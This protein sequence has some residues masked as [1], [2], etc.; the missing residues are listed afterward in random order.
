M[1]SLANALSVKADDLLKGSPQLARWR[2]VVR[3]TPQ[4]SDAE[5]VTLSMMPAMLGYTSEAPVATAYPDPAAAPVPVPAEAARL[6]QE[7]R[8]TAELIR[9]VMRQLATDTALWTDDMWVVASTPVECR[10]SR[11]TVKCSDLAGWAQYGSCVSHTRYF[12]GLRLYLLCT[13]GG[14]PIAFAL[15]G[16]KADERETRLGI[17]GHR[18][19]AGH[20]PATPQGSPARG[21]VGRVAR[22]G[23][24]HRRPQ[25]RA[26]G[27]EFVPNGGRPA[28]VALGPSRP[29][30]VQPP[31]REILAPMGDPAP[32]HHPR[33]SA[34]GSRSNG[35]RRPSAPQRRSSPSRGPGGAATRRPA[36]APGPAPRRH[37]DHPHPEYN[38]GAVCDWAQ[39]TGVD[40]TIVRAC[41]QEPAR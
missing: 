16:A 20:R 36:F 39:G 12:W 8:M 37:H 17:F 29:E 6:Q 32:A 41:R 35:P 5:L 7:V 26:S 33:P 1:D 15:T 40:P 19:D 4:L 11:E 3:I 2:P 24:R 31:A 30:P 28:T 13:L 22:H 21:G 23:L 18:T 9:H 25:A 10:R 14:L 27:R 38:P 34:P